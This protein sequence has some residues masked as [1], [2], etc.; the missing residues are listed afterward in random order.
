MKV[1]YCST[2]ARIEI[3]LRSTFWLRASDSNRSSGPSQLSSDNCSASSRSGAAGTIS[4]SSG[5]A[6]IGESGR[7][8]QRVALINE[9]RELAAVAI[10]RNPVH[11]ALQPRARYGADRVERI[12]D[13]D[14]IVH[15]SP[16]I[17]RDVA[18]GGD[19]VGGARG[20]VARQRL[21][22]EIVGHQQAVETRPEEHTSEL[23]SLM[24]N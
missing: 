5:S 18:A 24:R 11:R 7:R 12:R 14:H 10:A 21:H 3:C 22:V 1:R 20:H 8:Q 23:Q 16:A 4:K 6:S 15:L 2:S 19:R 13:A 17:E 9:R